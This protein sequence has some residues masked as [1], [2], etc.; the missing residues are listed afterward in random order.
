MLQM[1]ASLDRQF[2]GTPFADWIT[3]AAIAL[4]VVLV[5]L[6]LKYVVGRRLASLASR[7]TSR[8]DDVVAELLHRTRLYFII[9]LAARATLPILALS[10]SIVKVAEDVTAIAFLLQIARWGTGLIDFWLRQWSRGRPGGDERATSATIKAVAALAQAVLWSVVLLLAL[11]N[12]WDFDITALVTGLGVGGIAVALAVQNILGDAFAALSIVL[13]KPFDIGDTIAVDTSVGT[14]EHI[15]LKTTRIRAL[16][17]EQIIFSNAELLKLRVRN[18]RRMH[19]RRV[20]FTLGVTYD[21]PADAVERIPATIRTIIEAT[22]TTR[23][24]RAHFAR[25]MD[26]SLEFEAVYYVNSPEFSVYM[27]TQQAIN[28]ALLRSF[29]DSG[30][31]FAFPTR[32]IIQ[33]RDSADDDRQRD[34]PT[35]VVEGGAPAD[36]IDTA[37]AARTATDD[38]PSA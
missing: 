15:G 36:G 30:I 19:E 8:V 37:G 20:V 3:A 33:Q 4:A 18:L 9:A 12:V 16:S 26:S 11:K 22:P 38:A 29:N 5:L 27:D 17:G 31:S 6:M 32:T 14:V 35:H 21:T 25:Y 7:T 10:Q 1:L 28:L 34:A 24:D 2:L 13:D 23:F